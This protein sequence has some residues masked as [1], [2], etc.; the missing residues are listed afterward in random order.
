MIRSKDIFFKDFIY[1]FMRDTERKQRQRQRE[2]K[3]APHREPDAGLDP[4][5][6]GS[7]PGPKADAQLLSH[8]GVPKR[9]FK[10]KR[11]LVVRASCSD[12]G[13]VFKIYHLF[14]VNYEKKMP[15]LEVYPGTLQIKIY[16]QFFGK[17]DYGRLSLI[18]HQL[19]F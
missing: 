19:L 15:N 8:P 18:G 1:S 13:F 7:C 16:F 11:G 9:H 2:E 6:P 10:M 14:S 5:T 17:G 12:W 4:R 3:Q